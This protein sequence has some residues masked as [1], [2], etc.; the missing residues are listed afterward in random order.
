MLKPVKKKL[1]PAPELPA[2]EE[3]QTAPA[4]EANWTQPDENVSYYEE[5][6]EPQAWFYK[7]LGKERG[8]VS[9]ET[10]AQLAADN[11]IGPET[12]VR[13]GSS[14]DWVI[15]DKIPGLFSIAG[16]KARSQT[17]PNPPGLQ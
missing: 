15:A 1:S 14:P 6:T 5:R 9:F 4:V 7:E 11:E 12:R 16:T 13:K 3:A 2:E 17:K 8:P 10:L